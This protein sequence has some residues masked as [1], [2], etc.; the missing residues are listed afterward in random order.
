MGGIQAHVRCLRASLPAGIEC[1][2]IGED[3]PFAGKSG[4]DWTEW[5]QISR[6]VREFCP[7]I[8]HLHTTPLLMSLWLRLFSHVPRIVSLHTSQCARPSL[9][10]R[11]LH[12]LLYPCYYLPVSAEVWKNFK[13]W[14]PSAQGQV[15]VNPLRV[16]ALPEKREVV[17]SLIVGMVGRAA[18]VKD[19]PSFHRVEA[20]VKAQMPD[21]EFWNLGEETFCPNGAE[22]IGQM[23]LFL[24]T[25]FSEAMP[26]TMLEAFGMRTAVCGF[27]PVGGVS[28]ILAFSG[29]PLRDVFL[30]A[31]DCV[32][33]AKK[34]MELLRNPERRA[35]LVQD[36]VRILAEH[37]EAEKVVPNLLVPIYRDLIAKNL[38]DV[39][40]RKDKVYNA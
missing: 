38:N 37:F 25:S 31:R 34:V 4:H 20:L 1:Y 24:M 5:H 6:I 23:D 2:V 33:L 35:L 19:W 10:N 13:R 36:G 40:Q 30:K 18:A 17:R 26:T 27:I 8:I 21:V 15:F 22:R 12:G 39:S 11:I 3:E 29:G 16:S 7:D 28:E 9:K 32:V 14:F